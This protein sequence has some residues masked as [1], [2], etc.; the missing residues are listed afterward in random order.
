[1]EENGPALGTSRDPIA[2]WKK[3]VL[4]AYCDNTTCRR[5]KVKSAG[6]D[7][8]VWCP[9]CSNALIYKRV[10]NVRDLDLNEG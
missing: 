6:K 4:I 9:N 2:Q 1:M 5:P 3:Q 8:G 10:N 7:I